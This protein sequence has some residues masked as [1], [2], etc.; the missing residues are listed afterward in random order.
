MVSGPSALRS[1]EMK[2]CSDATA[3]RGGSPAHSASISRSLETTRPA[4][5]S[6]SARSARCFVPP[7]GSDLPATTASSGPRILNSSTCRF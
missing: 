2:F 7:S 3:V 6:S 4:S 1:C 5:R